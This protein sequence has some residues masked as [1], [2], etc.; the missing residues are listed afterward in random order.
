MKI[1]I[2]KK[3][4]SKTIWNKLNFQIK[5]LN[6]INSP[7][8]ARII[9]IILIF[10]IEKIPIKMMVVIIIE[11]MEIKWTPIIKEITTIIKWIQ[12]IQIIIKEIM[13]EIIK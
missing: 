9:L 3:N 5:I 10:Q 12:I 8:R 7:I 1:K 4:N 13:E 2:K 11:I 6:K